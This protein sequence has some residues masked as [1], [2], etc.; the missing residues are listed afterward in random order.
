MPSNLSLQMII[1]II[2]CAALI[3]L[4]LFKKGPKTLSGFLI[5]V[6]WCAAILVVMNNWETAMQLYRMAAP[7][8]QAALQPIVHQITGGH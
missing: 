5:V 3:L 6:L 4:Y 7:Q 2:L 8:V 1:G